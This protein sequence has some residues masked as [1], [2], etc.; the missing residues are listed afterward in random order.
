MSSDDFE[1]D[2]LEVVFEAPDYREVMS[3]SLDV[4]ISARVYV[5]GV[6]NG[7]LEPIAVM[8][9]IE[10]LDAEGGIILRNADTGSFTD[11]LKYIDPNA[12][13]IIYSKID[14]ALHNLF[15]SKNA[16]EIRELLDAIDSIEVSAVCDNV[17]LQQFRTSLR[18]FIH[19]FGE[20]SCILDE[21]EFDEEGGE[22]EA[23]E[24]TPK[25]ELN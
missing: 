3:R 16:S 7:P 19:P 21:E 2:D 1:N 5:D 4:Q 10:D 22:N 15:I 20:V 11:E 6:L 23:A 14:I 24:M 12:K 25:S 9:Y 17:T 8:G 18:I 13:N